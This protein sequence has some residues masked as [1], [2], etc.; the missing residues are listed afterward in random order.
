M[1]LI[2][3]E[4]ILKRNASL[5][6]FF[7]DFSYVKNFIIPCKYNSYRQML[8]NEPLHVSKEHINKNNYVIYP[9]ARNI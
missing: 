1:S 9:V 5:E 4:Y 2:S 7:Y 3:F 6:I 8:T